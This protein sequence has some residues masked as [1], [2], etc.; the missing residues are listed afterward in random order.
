MMT[1]CFDMSK[2]EAAAHLGFARDNFDRICKERGGRK[3]PFKVY[4]GYPARLF[5][6]ITTPV[7]DMHVSVRTAL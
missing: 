2:L 1:A 6:R 3:W 5:D 4:K 7:H